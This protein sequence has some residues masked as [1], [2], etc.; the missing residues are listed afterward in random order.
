MN[1]DNAADYYYFDQKYYST[2]FSKLLTDAQIFYAEKDGEIIASSIILK[3]KD[4]LNYHLSGSLKAPGS[5]SQAVF[6]S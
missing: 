5:L 4:K 2:L 6:Q 1:R 3:C